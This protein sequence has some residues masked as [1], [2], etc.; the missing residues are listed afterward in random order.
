[1]T[2][3]ELADWIQEKSRASICRAGDELKPVAQ[4]ADEA[5]ESGGD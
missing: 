4:T 2:V 3:A 5:G 1:M